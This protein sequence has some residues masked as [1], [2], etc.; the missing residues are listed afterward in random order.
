MSPTQ[1][2]KKPRTNNWLSRIKDD[3]SRPMSSPFEGN[4]SITPFPDLDSAGKFSINPGRFSPSRSPI[5]N[6]CCSIKQPVSGGLKGLQ[7][8]PPAACHFARLVLAQA[9]GLY[10]H[11]FT[12]LFHRPIQPVPP[13]L[14][15]FYTFLESAL[16]LHT[17]SWH[18]LATQKSAFFLDFMSHSQEPVS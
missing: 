17:H 15:D 5:L 16:G 12:A 3:P 2:D 7:G 11:I 6:P 4:K 10:S 9:N 14:F 18:F 13:N 8:L 1:K